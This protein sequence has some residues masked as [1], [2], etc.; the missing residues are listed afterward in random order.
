MSEVNTTGINQLMI[1]KKTRQLQFWPPNNHPRNLPFP[2]PSRNF[3]SPAIGQLSAYPPKFIVSLQMQTP[4]RHISLKPELYHRIIPYIQ[5]TMTFHP[6]IMTNSWD[7][8][9]ESEWSDCASDSDCDSVLSISST[10][11]KCSKP[12]LERDSHSKF[13]INTLLS[14]NVSQ[15]ALDKLKALEKWIRV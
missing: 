11:F 12:A 10:S 8:N 5:F 7:L 4:H 15:E 13:I 9:S 14:D 6:T 2:H 3:P 1:T